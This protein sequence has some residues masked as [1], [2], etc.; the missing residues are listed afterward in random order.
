MW[1]FIDDA[2]EIVMR[3]FGLGCSIVGACYSP[4]IAAGYDLHPKY[5]SLFAVVGLWMGGS[6]RFRSRKPS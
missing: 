3:I 2:S 1:K 6:A 5:V 4:W